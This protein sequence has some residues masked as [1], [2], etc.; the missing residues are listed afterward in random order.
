MESRFNTTCCK[1]SESPQTKNFGFWILDFGLF[2]IS[3]YG[4][5]SGFSPVDPNRKSKIENR[6]SIAL[7]FAIGGTTSIAEAIAST[8][9]K[10]RQSSESSPLIMREISSRSSIS[11]ICKLA[12]RSIVSIAIAALSSSSMPA[13]NIPAH[14]RIAVMGVRNSWETIA[15]NSSFERLAASASERAACSRTSNCSRSASA[16]LRPVMSCIILA[17]PRRLPSCKAVMTQ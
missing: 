17:K 16:C 12:L 14:P 5:N 11:C 7:A 9:S 6:K 4:I 13:C 8:T 15:R 1:R 10:M 2:S 3:W